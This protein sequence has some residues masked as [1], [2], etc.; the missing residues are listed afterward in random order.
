MKVIMVAGKKEKDPNKIYTCPLEVPESVEEAK[1]VWGEEATLSNCVANVVISYR[2][3]MMA[4]MEKGLTNEE[5]TTQLGNGKWRPGVAAQ[6]KADPEKVLMEKAKA[7]PEYRKKLIA[8][9]QQEAKAA[10]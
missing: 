2:G 1:K 5:V 8:L 6:L 10:K 7:D 9:L 4:G 3:K